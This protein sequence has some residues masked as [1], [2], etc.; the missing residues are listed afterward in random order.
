KAMTFAERNI[1]SAFEFAQDLVQARDLQ[2]VLRLQADYIRRQMQA[3]HEQAQE[4]G[5]SQQGGE[6]RGY[7]EKL[8]G[9][10]KLVWS[11]LIVRRNIS[12]ALHQKA[13]Y[14][15]RHPGGSGVCG[16]RRRPRVA[17]TPGMDQ[18]RA[19]IRA[20]PNC[21]PSKGSLYDRGYRD[22][23]LQVQIQGGFAGRVR[24]AE[25]RIAELRDSQN[26]NSGRLPRDRREERL[27]GERDLRKDEICR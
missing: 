18:H 1:T 19:R 22:D 3:L 14:M 21:R 20:T 8:S 9:A 6:G 25:I 12:V 27:A 7:A 16:L 4:L 26:G 5:E 15:R 11:L 23:Q 2:E 13:R 17:V 24:H 10:K